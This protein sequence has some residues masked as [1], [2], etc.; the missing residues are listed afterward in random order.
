MNAS[1]NGRNA[2]HHR[3]IV[4]EIA[5]REIIRRINYDVESSHDVERICRGETSVECLDGNV[6]IG[7]E[8]PLARDVDFRTADICS[9]IQDLPMYV[10][11]IDFVE[12]DDSNHARSRGRKVDRSRTAESA[13]TNDENSRRREPPLSLNSEFRKRKL[14]AVPFQFFFCE[15]LRA[16]HG[17]E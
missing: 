17:Q 2:E 6:R 1:I 16:D 8:Y 11:Q 7:A 15:R 5:R 3:S 14:S 13:G 10:G 4:H 9:R 12:I